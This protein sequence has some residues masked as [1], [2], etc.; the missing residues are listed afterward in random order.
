MVTGAAVAAADIDAAAVVVLLVA[1]HG[2]RRRRPF[3]MDEKRPQWYYLRFVSRVGGTVSFVR[4]RSSM[5]M[6][7][8]VRTSMHL[9]DEAAL[10]LGGA[11]M[12]VRSLVV[13][14][15]TA[16]RLLCVIQQTSSVWGERPSRPER[17]H[18]QT[19]GPH[20]QQDRIPPSLACTVKLICAM[21]MGVGVVDL[22]GRRWIGERLR[23]D[24][25]PEVSRFTFTPGGDAAA[26][27]DMI[28]MMCQKASDGARRAAPPKP[29][30]AY[31]S[32]GFSLRN[33]SSF[34]E[35][36][37]SFDVEAAQRTPLSKEERYP[38]KL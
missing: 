36:E 34:F 1:A 14:P 32:R 31:R 20:S 12:L 17:G 18:R 5:Y 22:L 19:D 15:C 37:S 11:S 29:W 26:A 9:R 3:V 24:T 13:P 33:G 25:E 30:G 21:G 4:V 8:L 6:Y 23:G 10:L 2:S 7:R 27:T 16:E 35:I 28:R 38:L